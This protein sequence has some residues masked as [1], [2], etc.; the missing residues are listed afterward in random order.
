MDEN[1]NDKFIIGDNTDGYRRSANDY[2]LDLFSER[3]KPVEN[4][5]EKGN[6]KKNAAK[7]NFFSRKPS[8]PVPEK[9][10]PSVKRHAK[11][12]QPARM[13]RPTQN[14]TASRPVQG[15]KRPGPTANG[16][17]LSP[18]ERRRLHAEQRRAQRRR[19]QIIQ[20]A[21]IGV[22]VAAVMLVLSLT[23]FFKIDEIKVEGDTPYSVE[24]IIAASGINLDENIITCDA[25]SVSD[26][27]AKALPYIGSA[28]VKR[29][30]NGKV[31]ITVKLT[32]GCYSFVSGENA[33]IVD[34][35]GK[36]L[37]HAVKDE[38]PKYIQVSG[39]EVTG[40]Q[41]GETVELS[42]KGAF[43]LIQN[44]RTKFADAGIN[45][46]TSVDVKDIYDL[47][48]S[49]DGRITIKLG[50]TASLDR[51]I[52]LGAKT[53]EREDEVDPTQCGTLFLG[54]QEGKATFRPAEK[55]QKEETDIV[56]DGESPEDTSDTD[57]AADVPESTTA[58]A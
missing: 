49:Y 19:K 40:A 56:D 26:N 42:D 44:L 2:D 13:A 27:L 34:A 10:G 58:S 25:D 52:A 23:V 35:N 36:V 3:K 28:E 32:A 6:P 31:V 4:Q 45:K 37:E 5:T 17:A 29:S 24:E 30:L 20:Y 38:A 12:P 9:K 22:A 21:L 18:N 14:T 57:G 8:Q 55:P 11:P 48:L 50:D 54:S 46:L 53:I 1:N 33:I 43:D 47:T 7:Q 39:V 15:R 41:L 51:K 16:Q